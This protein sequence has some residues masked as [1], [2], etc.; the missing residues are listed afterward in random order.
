MQFLFP[1]DPTVP[2]VTDR[3]MM[4]DRL[5]QFFVD[6]SK[7]PILS[8]SGS[9]EGVIAAEVTRLYMDEDGTSGSVLYIKQK[10]IFPAIQPKA[11]F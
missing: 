2:I 11:G 10:Q 5:R 9:P 4:V 6:A 3:G 8:G 7:L 1:P